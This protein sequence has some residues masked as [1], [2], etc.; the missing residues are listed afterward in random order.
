M[1]KM[2]ILSRNNVNV[3][4]NPVSNLKLANGVAPVK[5]MLRKGINVCIGTDSAASN[6][7]LNLFKEMSICSLIHKGINNDAEIVTASDSLRFATL[8]GAKAL[9]LENKLGAIKEGYLADLIIIDIDKPQYYP[10]NNLISALV[11]STYGNEVET[12]IV[13]GKIL[14]LENELKTIDVEK[15]KFEVMNINERL[16]KR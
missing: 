6:N 15:I 5:E 2:S 16:R 7:S 14:M 9:G 8:N 10:R 13:N 1:L 11:Y 4:T 12:V 3:V